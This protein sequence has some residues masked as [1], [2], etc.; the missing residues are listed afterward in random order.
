M[1]LPAVR[2]SRLAMHPHLSASRLLSNTNKGPVSNN[3]YPASAADSAGSKKGPVS[4][5]PYPASPA[6]AADSAGSKKSGWGLD[7]VA[8]VGVGLTIIGTLI[9]TSVAQTVAKYESI[10]QLAGRDAQ[11]DA[12]LAGR[13]AQRDA[14]QAGRD[15]QLAERLSRMTFASQHPRHV[16]DIF[17]DPRNAKEVMEDSKYYK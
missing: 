16:K 13:D 1:H 11:R 2:F 9:G 12:Q 8:I 5:N 7:V 4:N 10:A 14:Q 6:S 17:A 3:P 15:A